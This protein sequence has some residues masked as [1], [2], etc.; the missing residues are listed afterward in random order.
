MCFYHPI[1]PKSGV[2]LPQ[3][4]PQ[5]HILFPH[6][7][8]KC[9][10]SSCSPQVPPQHWRSNWVMRDPLLLQ[11]GGLLT[12]QILGGFQERNPN[13]F[14]TWQRAACQPSL[15]K[16]ILVSE[17]RRCVKI[18]GA[19]NW[20]YFCLQRPCCYKILWMLPS[21]VFAWQKHNRS[22]KLNSSHL[23]VVQ[24]H[25]QPCLPVLPLSS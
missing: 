2:Y 1:F 17:G 12:L 25:N 20:I 19:W 3:D 22:P 6:R 24:S 16:N 8:Q 4:Q 13:C 11:L 7:Q 14:A 5:D 9:S 21:L 15:Q 18:S 10:S 23:Q